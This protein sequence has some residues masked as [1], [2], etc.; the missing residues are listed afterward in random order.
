MQL[1]EINSGVFQDSVGAMLYLLYIVNL[2]IALDSTIAND[3][4][5][6]THDNPIEVSPRLQK[7]LSYIQR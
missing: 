2:P 5:L 4:I 1:K 3:T 6:V 7:N